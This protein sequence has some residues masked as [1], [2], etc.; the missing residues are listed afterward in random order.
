MSD[1]FSKRDLK[2]AVVF[3]VA[4]LSLVP[5]SLGALLLSEVVPRFPGPLDGL[6]TPIFDLPQ[7]AFPTDLRGPHGPVPSWLTPAAWIML[8]VL[9]A[10]GTRRLRFRWV[11]VIALPVVVLCTYASTA[12]FDNYGYFYTLDGP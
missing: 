2:A 8:A 1:W 7:H 3:L 6:V 10:L 11:V 4:T 12:I 9:F 5:I